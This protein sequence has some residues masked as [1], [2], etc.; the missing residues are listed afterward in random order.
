MTMAPPPAMSM[1]SP[2]RMSVK[3]PVAFAAGR[4]STTQTF[5]ARAVEKWMATGRPAR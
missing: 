4:S 1:R 3:G 5:S 2:G